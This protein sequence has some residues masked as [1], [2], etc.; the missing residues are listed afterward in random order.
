MTDIYSQAVE[1]RAYIENTSMRVTHAEVKRAANGQIGFAKV[2]GIVANTDTIK[3]DKQVRVEINGENMFTGRLESAT[4]DDAGIVTIEA[5][6]MLMQ[7]QDKYVIL[8]PD[9]PRY[10]R[11]VI[12]DLLTEAGVDVYGSYSRADAGDAY[13]AGEPRETAGGVATGEE[14]DDIVSDN[15]DRKFP[16]GDT[17]GRREYGSGKQGEM[18]TLVLQ[19]LVTKLGGIM[20]VDRHNI[21]RIEPYPMHGK[22]G[23]NFIIE[24]NSGDKKVENERVIVKGGSPVSELGPAAYRMYS[25]VSN[26]SRA[27]VGDSKDDGKT[28]TIEDQNII[29]QKEANKVATSSMFTSAFFTNNGG[30]KTVGSPR[31]ELFDEVRVP[32]LSED[33]A[34]GTVNPELRDALTSEEFAIQG[35][36]HLVTSK[37]GYTTKLDL[38]PNPNSVANGINSLSDAIS[39]ELKD[40]IEES[41]TD[42]GNPLNFIPGFE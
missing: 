19:D 10:I 25:Q 37:D 17:L 29:T 36:T 3:P 9:Q 40:R 18:L 33:S 7:L 8:D 38:A 12:K 34:G 15:P 14:L 31:Y 11:P 2:K 13:L 24:K 1:A 21:L 28:R 6:D 16:G 22:Y 39:A 26:S 5:Y 30:V 20:W 27:A 23:V 41:E 32:G 35:V 42:K 4:Q